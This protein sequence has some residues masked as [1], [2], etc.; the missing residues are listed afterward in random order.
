[1]GH[2]KYTDTCVICGYQFHADEDDSMIIAGRIRPVCPNCSGKLR[3]ATAP[4][5]YRV[6][7]YM[8]PKK[9]ELADSWLTSEGVFDSN[10]AE[11]DGVEITIVSV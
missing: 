5:L 3:A 8:T 2:N 7:V 11:D 4:Y 10:I 6:K 1:M 9:E